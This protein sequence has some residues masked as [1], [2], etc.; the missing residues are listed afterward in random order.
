MNTE[1]LVIK[2][3]R[4][5]KDRLYMYCDEDMILNLGTLAKRKGMKTSPYARMIL[6]NHI[7]TELKK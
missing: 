6:L 4:Q 7:E 5:F 2:P 1:A 3:F